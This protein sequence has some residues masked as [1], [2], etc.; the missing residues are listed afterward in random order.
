MHDEGFSDAQANVLERYGLVAQDRWVPTPTVDG[1][2]HVLVTGDGPPVVLLNGIGVPAAML[3]PL[4]ARIDGFTQYAIDLPAYGLSDTTNGFADDLRA[5]AVGFLCDVFDGLGLADPTIVAN[6]L[7]SLWASWLAIDEPDRVAALAY[8]GC[9]AVV[10]DTSA[11]L[12]MRLLSVRRLGRLMIR[13]Q[14]PSER[15][16]ERLAKTVHEH[17]LPPEITQL[18]VATERL[19][20]FE[21]TFLA[22]LNQLIRLRGNRPEHALT[23]E[24]LA[25]IDLPTLLVFANDDPMGGPSVGERVA[26]AMP[27]ADLHIVDGGHAPWLHHAAQIAPLLE[28]FLHRTSRSEHT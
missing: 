9:P 4:M 25:T 23:A 20:H 5:N 19:D 3:A 28:P 7:G 2:A 13:L 6:S 10:L 18:I 16:V 11:P 1:Q 21:E 12:P 15:Q 26:A 27:D 17:P 24:Q 8:I 22:T 14:P